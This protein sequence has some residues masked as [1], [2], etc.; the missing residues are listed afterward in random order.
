VQVGDDVVIHIAGNGLFATARVAGPAK[1][2]RDRAR[3]YGAPLDRIRLIQPPVSLD[4]VLREIPALKWATYPRSIT[5]VQP[6]VAEKLRALIKTRRAMRRARAGRI[7]DI[8]QLNSEELYSVAISRSRRRVGGSTRMITVRVRDAAVK[9]YVL[10]R[11]GGVCE[12]CRKHGPF[13]DLKGHVYL[14][15]HHVTRLADEG[16]DHP[17]NGIAICPNCHRKAHHSA[18]KVA[19]RRQMDRRVRI[20]E[21]RRGH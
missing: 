13:K 21:Q 17:K 20:L 16:P 6:K 7:A 3:R 14:E 4:V 12:F 9:A 10:D 19:V 11:A 15:I 2:R 1:R 18:D 5:T 8:R